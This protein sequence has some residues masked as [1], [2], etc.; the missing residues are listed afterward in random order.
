LRSLAIGAISTLTLSARSLLS[1]KQD[2][3]EQ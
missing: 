2:S 3:P 1:T